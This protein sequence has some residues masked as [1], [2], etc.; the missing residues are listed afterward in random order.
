MKHSIIKNYITWVNETLQ[1]SEA[2]PALDANSLL[3]MKNRDSMVDLAISSDSDTLKANPI[4][5]PIMDWWKRGGGDIGL[6]KSIVKSGANIKGDENLSLKSAYYWA[7]AGAT[8]GSAIRTDLAIKVGDAIVANAQKIGLEQPKSDQLKQALDLLRANQQKGIVLSN[9]VYLSSI[10]PSKL[11]GNTF[12]LNGAPVNVISELSKPEVNSALITAIK[13]WQFSGDDAELRKD[14]LTSINWLI[15]KQSDPKLGFWTASIKLTEQDKADI[16]TEFT[17]KATDYMNKKNDPSLTI[18]KIISS[19]TNLYIAPKNE[20]VTLQ[21]PPPTTPQ[22]PTVVTFSYPGNPKG[23][24]NS[25]SF[26]RGLKLFPDDGATLTPTALS[27]INNAVKEILNSIKLTGGTVTAARTWGVSSTSKVGTTYGS[28]NNIST[29]ENNVKLAND[30]LASI[31]K[32]FADS[33]KSNGISITPTVLTNMNVARPNQG[34]DWT[35]AQKKDPK[36]GAPGSRTAI[37]ETTYGPH[38]YAIGFC[39]F[40]VTIPPNTKPQLTGQLVGNGQW[41]AMIGWADES[42]K[43]KIPAFN[44]I[45]SYV[46]TPRLAVGECPSF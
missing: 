18:D 22:Q 28:T 35:D 29:P 23:D 20:T 11:R 38:R 43:I 34:P 39:Q 44:Y 12:S 14:P 13:S 24:P 3:K 25:D 5:K 42:I 19:A 16:L 21:Q 2:A 46:S 31:N 27:E 37:Y 32:A 7:G 26:K 6:I 41:K 4:Y 17:N 36:F 45:S 40:A 15:Q 10:I 1:L 33:I 9:E 8:K 30:R